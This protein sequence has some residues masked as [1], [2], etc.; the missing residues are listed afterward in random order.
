V[1]SVALGGTDAADFSLLGEC[2]VVRPGESCA[3]DVT[4]APK[5]AGGR[6]AELVVTSD[7]TTAA[8]SLVQ[9]IP[10]VGEGAVPLPSL[11]TPSLGFGEVETGEES[12]EQQ[13]V[14]KNLGNA[15][16][17][18]DAVSV[19]GKDAGA[20]SVASETCQSTTL[21]PGDDCKVGVVF[22]PG[23]EGGLAATLQF[24]TNADAAVE[25]SLGGTGTAPHAVVSADSL[26]FGTVLLGDRASL[27][28]ELVNKGTAP[29][30][31]D[32]LRVLGDE[33]SL[34]ADC[35]DALAPGDACRIVVT[36]A[37]RAAGEWKGE[38]VLPDGGGVTVK[39]IGTGRDPRSAP[40]A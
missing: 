26:D 31:L 35:R 13:V 20:F 2:T 25:V 34:E 9:R 21:A 5:A 15:P 19:S 18:V 40:R 27:D 29:L 12:G 33:Y 4:F 28:L 30:R 39:L 16:L 11:S 36:F 7:A 10:L 22:A 17:V 32:G 8:T 14:L 6:S 38:L 3:V 23:A 24:A 37:P 1:S